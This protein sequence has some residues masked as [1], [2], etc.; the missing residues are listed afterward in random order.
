MI[1]NCTIRERSNHRF[2][3]THDLIAAYRAG[4][5]EA[6]ALWLT[7]IRALACAITSFINVLDPEIIIIGGGIA[8]A[9]DALFGPLREHLDEIEWRPG[10][11]RVSV[12]PAQLGSLP[13][14][15]AQPGTP[16]SR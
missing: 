6:S 14:R 8:R 3:S 16:P 7:S 13:A 1:G 2:D 11:Q 15:S 5:P 10:G 9:S 12:R 4:D